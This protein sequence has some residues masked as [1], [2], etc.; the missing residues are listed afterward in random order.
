MKFQTLKFIFL[1]MAFAIPSKHEA[2][3]NKSS[4]NAAASGIL[5]GCP[6]TQ[7]LVKK[8]VPLKFESCIKYLKE[9]SL[10]ISRISFRLVSLIFI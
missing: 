7:C 2:L 3:G 4:A 9:N 10:G 1:A 5:S 8:L 6:K